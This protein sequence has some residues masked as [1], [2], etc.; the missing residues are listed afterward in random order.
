M[1]S[2]MIPL[3]LIHYR[4][5]PLAILSLNLIVVDDVQWPIQGDL[6][7]HLQVNSSTV[8]KNKFSKK[9]KEEKMK[10][11]VVLCLKL[12]MESSDSPENDVMYAWA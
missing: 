10:L 5:I 9:G 1:Q 3:Q 4:L 6:V 11:P 2:Q 12:R 8:R 7:Q